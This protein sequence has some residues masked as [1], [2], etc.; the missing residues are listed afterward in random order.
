[1][2]LISLAITLIVIGSLNQTGD[3][4]VPQVR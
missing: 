2:P 3:I 1:M 4:R